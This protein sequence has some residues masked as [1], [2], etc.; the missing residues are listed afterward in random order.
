MKHCIYAVLLCVFTSAL[1][2]GD[3]EARNELNKGNVKRALQLFAQSCDNG[4]VSSC[5]E[6]G[7]LYSNGE[8]IK[9]D[10]HKSVSYYESAC[11]AGY[12]PA[13][14]NLGVLFFQ[15]LGVRQDYQRSL[16]LYDMSCQRGNADACNN[17]GVMFEN[18]YGIEK[19]DPVQAGLYYTDACI[20]KSPK[21]CYNLAVLAMEGKGVKKDKSMGKEYFGLSCDFGYQLGC[22]K[23]KQLNLK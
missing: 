14:N 1:M 21:G 2:A 23:Y 9:Q 16:E 17:L 20:G 10:Y 11:N 5:Y 3:K 15:G 18:G 13:C 8:N 7:I 12:L 4:D 22:D 6:L 19:K